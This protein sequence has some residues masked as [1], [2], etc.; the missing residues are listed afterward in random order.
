[1]CRHEHERAL[2]F[3]G[4]AGSPDAEA[5]A[6][7][8]LADAL[9]AQGRMLTAGTYFERC[10]AL[11]R[12]H[13]LGR[14]EVANRCMAALPL[15]FSCKTEAAHAAAIAA[16]EAASRVGHQRAEMIAGEIAHMVL[17]EMGDDTE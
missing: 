7:S 15:L 4:S 11:A 5:R 3:A 12:Q 6:L 9:Y 14:I 13:G 8:G 2:A 16:V 1:D 10:I 17:H